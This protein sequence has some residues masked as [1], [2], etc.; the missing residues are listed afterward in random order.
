MAKMTGANRWP[1]DAAAALRPYGEVAAT[2]D[3][4]T[5]AFSLNEI[6]AYWGGY[7]AEDRFAFIV[8]VR[9]FDRTTG[10][11]TYKF[12][13][14]LANNADFTGSVKTLSFDVVSKGIH[15]FVLDVDTL[16]K[17]LADANQVAISVDVGGTTPSIDFAVYVAPVVGS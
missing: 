11:E 5:A 4:R 7:P 1:Y 15:A 8:D 13:V 2:A 6:S 16:R 10:D 12:A 14:E 17:F 9:D 3:G